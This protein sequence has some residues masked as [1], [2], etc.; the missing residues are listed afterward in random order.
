M[1]ADFFLLAV[2]RYYYSSKPHTWFAFESTAQLPAAF[3][4]AEPDGPGLRQVTW[5]ENADIE[6][7]GAAEEQC[8]GLWGYASVCAS[9][10]ARTLGRASGRMP[11][12]GTGLAFQNRCCS[13]NLPFA[14]HWWFG[15]AEGAAAPAPPTC[16]Q[17]RARITPSPDSEATPQDC[18]DDTEAS[19][20]G[21]A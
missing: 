9:L 18:S 4:A 7:L 13:E 15:D 14:L 17:L 12:L 10:C 6:V 21:L 8:A 19:D 16:A 1:N 5:L 2:H 11:L 20:V 3:S